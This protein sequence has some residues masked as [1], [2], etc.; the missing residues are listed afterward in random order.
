MG[1]NLLGSRVLSGCVPVLTHFA[2]LTVI[3]ELPDGGSHAGAYPNPSNC[4]DREITMKSKQPSPPGRRSPS[5]THSRSSPAT[6]EQPMTGAART[7]DTP[8]GA[9]SAPPGTGFRFPPFELPKFEA[10]DEFRDLFEQSCTNF[11]KGS[12]EVGTKVIEVM[13]A[14]TNSAFEFA[15][16]LAG[17]K[18]FPEAAT[19][20]GTLARK[21]ME[22]CSSQAQEL[23]A[24]VQKV[25]ADTMGPLTSGFPQMFKTTGA[26]S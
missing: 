15:Q 24:L 26:T 13:T 20:Y 23:A 3:N 12:A 17:A 1:W 11:A 8:A 9:Q 2:E 5:R 16:G 7:Y 25:T 19:L 22:V 10:S 6:E 21:H 4:T 18:S 14:N